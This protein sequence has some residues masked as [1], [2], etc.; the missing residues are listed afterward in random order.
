M[1]AGFSVD[2]KHCENKGFENNEV[3]TITMFPCS[4]AK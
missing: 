2:R 3:Y 1:L 4:S